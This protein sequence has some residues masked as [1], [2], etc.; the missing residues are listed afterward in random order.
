MKAQKP[1]NG[2]LIKNDW[3]DTIRYQVTCECGQPDHEHDVWVEANEC[4]V[5][6]QIYVTVKT[7]FWSRTRWNH[8]WQLLTK[9]HVQCE[10]TIGLNRQ[11]AMNYATILHHAVEDVEQFRKT[12]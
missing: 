10:T 1:A 3:G 7:N 12:K 8:L 4:D 9:G 11:Q 6:V 2:I 5:E